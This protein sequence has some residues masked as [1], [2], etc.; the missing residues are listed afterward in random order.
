MNVEKYML[1]TAKALLKEKKVMFWEYEDSVVVSN[2]GCFAIM[3]Q[4]K[5]LRCRRCGTYG[6][7]TG[8]ISTAR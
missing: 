8:L 5:S 4:I 1:E 3:P 6:V 7:S 2:G